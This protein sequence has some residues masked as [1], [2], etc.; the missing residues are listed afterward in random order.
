MSESF[1]KESRENH[2]RKV[3]NG[4]A[5]AVTKQLDQWLVDLEREESI[6]ADWVAE[7]VLGLSNS[8][9]SQYRSDDQAR[10]LPYW[11]ALRIAGE[12]KRLDFLRATLSIIGV[13]VAWKHEAPLIPRESD[14]HTLA[15]LLALD[16]GK[17]LA[18]FIE[19]TSPSSEGAATITPSKK[20]QLAPIVHHLRRVA[21]DLDDR[22]SG[23]GLPDLEVAQ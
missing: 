11:A 7:Y 2:T 22:I 15:E 5:L 16:G 8:A 12:M 17:V 6:S 20:A 10:N 9:I 14:L 23:S 1:R 21:D 13:D 18:L 3:H 19:V 4:L